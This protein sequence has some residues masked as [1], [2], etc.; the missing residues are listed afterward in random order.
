MSTAGPA[1]PTRASSA[2]AQSPA[3]PFGFVQL[4]FGFRLGPPDGRYLVRDSADGPHTAVLVMGTL[5]AP[6][7]RLWRGRRGRD[8]A[9][10]EP[11][12][13]PTTR[14]TVVRPEPF[15]ARAEADE[16]LT[17]VRSS[18]GDEELNAALLVLNRALRA[19]RSAAAD[20]YSVDVTTERA[21]VA[22]I[23][24]GDGE[25]VASGRY[26]EAWEL[27]AFGARRVRR[28]M[29]SP[30][31]RYAAILGGRDRGLAGEELVLRARMDLDAG[32][33]REAALQ[34]RVA[35]EAL[36]AELPSGGREN[37]LIGDRGVIGDAANRALT[38]EVPPE[39]AGELT[40]AIERMEASLKR[41]RMGH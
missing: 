9:S 40:S 13:V 37:N 33:V 12:P 2:T 6:E 28:S 27:P 35:L 21:L 31:E 34:A 29:E 32:R 3:S 23:G 1:T 15:P 18:G 24:F 5:G 25:S 10:A 4:E 19:W 39:V 36:L 7:R 16:W 20:P 41:L 11:E 8:L 30:E 17:G 22:R 38:G 14:V 26:A